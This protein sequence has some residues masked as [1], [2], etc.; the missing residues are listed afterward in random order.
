M[1]KLLIS[2]IIILLL[3]LSYFAI[4]KGIKF[5]HIKSINDIK[6]ASQKLDSNFNQANEL[7]S[8]TYPAELQRLEDS[9][10]KLKISK[11]EYESK[12]V[13]NVGDGTIGGITVKTYKIHYLYTI[14]GNYKEDNGIKSI[15]LD[16]K[17]TE[18]TDIY[19]LEFTLVG[20]YTNVID[21][22]YE[23]ENDEELNFEIQ[24]LNIEQY[25]IQSSAIL[26][27]LEEPE[28]NKTES[29]YP[30]HDYTDIN[31]SSALKGEDYRPEDSKSETVYDP[32]WVKVKFTVEDI[33]ITLD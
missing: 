18:L 31:Q 17:S 14:L 3:I 19:D 5:L 16:L 15:N 29:E 25:S 22:L 33:G 6:Q 13:Y 24:K 11:Q 32:K 27:D 20:P 23:I 8:I 10:K 2:I 28:N 1:K 21:F 26:T 4:A 12:K 9:I 30:F 7:S